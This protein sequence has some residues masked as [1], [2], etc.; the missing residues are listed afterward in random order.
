[1]GKYI[2]CESG[3]V[4]EELRVKFQRRF[5]TETDIG[6]PKTL[7]EAKFGGAA[8]LQRAVEA[9]E[10]RQFEREGLRYY[11][12][13]ELMVGEGERVTNEKKLKRGNGVDDESYASLCDKLDSLGWRF[14]FSPAEQKA[15][16]V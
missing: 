14:D 13:T 7:A 9:G 10:V 5:K 2:V 15:C 1:M 11:A 16:V 6:I 3:P 8:A 12:W 4:Y